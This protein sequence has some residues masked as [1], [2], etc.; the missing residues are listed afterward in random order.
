MQVQRKIAANDPEHAKV[1]VDKKRN[2]KLLEAYINLPMGAHGSA[3]LPRVP[4]GCGARVAGKPSKVLHCMQLACVGLFAAAF[5]A[6]YTLARGHTHLLL[7][8]PTPPSILNQRGPL[9]HVVSLFPTHELAIIA[10][11]AQCLCHAHPHPHG[12][13]ITRGRIS[14]CYGGLHRSG[15][16]LQR[17][18]DADCQRLGPVL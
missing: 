3:R 12:R 13:N 11:A 8:P 10:C 17:R 5:H 4:H 9:V 6:P 16:E 15:T 1:L 18:C 14:A 2:E 7:T